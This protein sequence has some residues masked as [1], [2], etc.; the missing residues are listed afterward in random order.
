MAIAK[1]NIE[2][3]E[4]FR[5]SIETQRNAVS[6]NVEIVNSTVNEAKETVNLEKEKALALIEDIQETL[7]TLKIK[8]DEQQ[9]KI[10]RLQA[11]LSALEASEPTPAEELVVEPDEY[12]EERNLISVGS[13][14]YE[15]TSAHISW[16]NEVAKLESELQDEEARLSQMQAVEGQLQSILARVEQEQAKLE[17]IYSKLEA[18]LEEVN[19]QKKSF[20]GYSEDATDKLN[21]INSVLDDYLSTSISSYSLSSR[22]YNPSLILKTMIINSDPKTSESHIF[23]LSRSDSSSYHYARETVKNTKQYIE[24]TN[25]IKHEY[26]SCHL[27][28]KNLPDYFTL[29]DEEW[30]TLNNNREESAKDNKSWFYE[31]ITYNEFK[32]LITIGLLNSKS[33]ENIGD[34]KSVYMAKFPYSIGYT[35]YESEDKTPEKTQYL[36]IVIGRKRDGERVISAYP[37]RPKQAILNNIY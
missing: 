17:E 25:T 10:E 31:E 19:A 27:D 34:T 5:Q 12:D 15:E 26:E 11:E 9:N 32:N 29:T 18:S 35:V 14:Y 1:V 20:E 3:V 30:E 37:G 6:D 4:V 7:S 2:N 21:K 28:K 13:S 33:I 16:R 23:D 36:T 24:N 8:I 22:S